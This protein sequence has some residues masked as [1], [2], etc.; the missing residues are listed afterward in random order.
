MARYVENIIVGGGQAG[1]AASYYLTKA[2]RP[3]IVFER[4][5]HPAHAWR[6]Q[7]WDSFTL[8]TPNWML[9]MPGAEHEGDDPDGFLMRDQV[10][11]YLANYAARFRLPMHY[12]IEVKSIRQTGGTYSIET[13]D[14]EYESDH[15]IV[16]TGLYQGPKVPSFAAK[17]PA[18]IRQLHSSEYRNPGAL[19]QG[20]VVVVG[21]GQS[22]AQIAEELYQSGRRVFLCV[23][24]TLRVPRRYRGRDIHQWSELLGM[25]DRTVEQLQSPRE[26]FEVHPTISG[27][28]G[29]R[30][31]NLHQFARDGVVLLGR[32]QD[33]ENGTLILA[34]DLREH[35]VAADEFENR[36]TPAIDK[37]IEQ[38]GVPAPA[39]NLSTQRDGYN[40]PPILRLDLAAHGITSVIWAS[41]YTFDFSLVQLPVRDADGYPIQ[42]R[43][44][45]EYPGLYFLGM[46]WLHSRK[47]GLIYGVGKDAAAYV[48]SHLLTSRV[49]EAAERAS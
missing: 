12:G 15:V 16:A 29:G 41:G 11:D 18:Q 47:S 21:A 4:S 34:P 31:L 44:V 20:A 24:R 38:R 42:E 39:A 6:D 2:E 26:K 25:W 33:I 48:V 7:R 32:L 23:G 5:V 13:T 35:L 22:G 43:G 10:I 19:P 49:R 27:K 9:G 17:L 37:Y 28:A 1:L 3:N 14:G 40:A 30:T 45:T 46:P 8:V 36:T